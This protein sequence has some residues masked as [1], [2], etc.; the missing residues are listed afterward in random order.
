[1]ELIGD[2]VLVEFHFGP[3]EDSVSS[4]QTRCTF[5]AKHIIGSE[6]VL[7]APDGTRR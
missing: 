5:C 2:V 1:M 4:V 6:I 3:F 7:D